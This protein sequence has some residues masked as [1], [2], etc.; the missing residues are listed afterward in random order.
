MRVK[1]QTSDDGRNEKIRQEK[2]RSWI[3]IEET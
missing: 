3:K 2:K 1:I